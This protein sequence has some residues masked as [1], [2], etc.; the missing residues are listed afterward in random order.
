MF[1][2]NDERRM[3]YEISMV[4]PNRNLSSEFDLLEGSELKVA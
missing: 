4:V 1:S 3:I 2:N